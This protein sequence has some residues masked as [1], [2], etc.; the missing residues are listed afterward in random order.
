MTMGARRQSGFSLLEIAIGLVILGVITMA[1]W[2]F[3][4]TATQQ[5]RSYAQR[6][7]LTRA[8]DAVIGYTL[9][10]YRLPCPAS[11]NGGLEN[12]SLQ[13]GRLPYRTLGL[14]D[15]RAG[16]IRYG[17]LRRDSGTPGGDA[18]LAVARDRFFPLTVDKEG[19]ALLGPNTQGAVVNGLDFC[20]ALRNAMRLPLDAAF[21]HTQQALNPD[22]PAVNV[23]YALAMSAGLT[24]GFSGNQASSAPVFDAPQRPSSGG[25]TAYHDQVRAAGFAQLWSR[26][27]CGDAVAAAGHAQFDALAAVG[28][29]HRGL[30]EYKKQLEITEQLAIAD[31]ALSTADIASGGGALANATAELIEATASATGSVGAASFEVALA[32][33]A[34][35]AGAAA[36]TAGGVTEGISAAGLAAAKKN[37]DDIQPPI[38]SASSLY[39][40]VLIHATDA[41]HAGL[42]GAH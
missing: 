20:Q 3:M 37:L 18:D 21:L 7:L 30:E 38:D 23:G 40:D 33:A 6:D 27:R 9:V 36:V 8:D 16:A 22:Q 19:N 35:V 31:V 32:T 17:V 4:G 42:Y 14:P 25:A 10:N 39:D 41:D 24:E 12:C 29:M 1:L 2:Q 26:L 15:A 28:L 34:E 11:D 5:R 13:V